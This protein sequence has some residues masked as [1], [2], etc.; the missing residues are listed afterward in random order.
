LGDGQNAFLPFNRSEFHS[1][2]WEYIQE[3][4]IPVDFSTAVDDYFET[5]KEAGVIFA[6]GLN[7]TADIIV[8]ADGVGYKSWSL[9]L[10]EKDVAISLGF[11]CYRATFPA[12]DALKNPRIAKGIRKPA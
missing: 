12:S 4:G 9:D 2:L 6:D 1:L 11:A 10:G 5:G 3:L 7:V 8:A